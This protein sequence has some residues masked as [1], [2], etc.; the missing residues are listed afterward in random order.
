MRLRIA[1]MAVL[2]LTVGC[3]TD[4][5]KSEPAGGGG[6]DD[7]GPQGCAPGELVLG[8]GACLPAGIA[9][10]ECGQGFEPE[11]DGCA[12]ILPDAACPTGQ[13]VI[14][15]ETACHE[16]APCGDAPWGEIPIEAATVFVDQSFVGVSDGSEAA[17][18]TTVVEGVAAAP[19]GGMVAIAAG[20]YD[21]N[22][23]VTKPLRIWGR[24]PDLVELHGTAL[25]QPAFTVASGAMSAEVHSLSI[26]AV[27]FGLAVTGADVAV[28]RVWF[29][30]VGQISAVSQNDLGDATLIVTNSLFSEHGNVAFGA[31]GATAILEDSMVRDGFGAGVGAHIVTHDVN[32]APANGTVR[33]SYFSNN[34]STAINIL[35]STALIEDTVIDDTQPTASGLGGAGLQASTHPTHPNRSD[36]TVERSVFRRN[37][38]AGIL[39]HDTDLLIGH[40]VVRDTESQPVD[41]EGGDGVRVWTDTGAAVDSTMS[42]RSSL[43]DNNSSLGIFTYGAQANIEATIVRD[44]RSRAKDGL[45]GRGIAIQ[46]DPLTLES[47]V[48]TVNGCLVEGNRSSNIS[49]IG[50]EATILYTHVRDG[51][52]REED[53]NFGRGINV[54]LYAMPADP[55]Y[56]RRSNATISNVLVEDN[57]DAGIAIVGADVVMNNVAVFDTLAR[58][59][60]DGFGDGIVIDL[61]AA[62]VT[63][64]A[65]SLVADNINIQRNARA[66]LGNFAASVTVGNSVISCNTIDMAGEN[67]QGPFEFEDSGANVCGC[68]TE[69]IC[70]VLSSNLDP[71]AAIEPP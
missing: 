61:Y 17:P 52:P 69:K 44:T 66:G 32:G 9:P 67:A 14:P 56:A 49:V 37:H 45:T 54:Q 30:N 7:P 43:V 8:D 12:P 25:S 16:V 33:R 50:S 20:T 59:S 58:E 2:L 34:K 5:T 71:P 29:H 10:L 3:T 24:C 13:M 28:D 26:S 15:G 19:A 38:T 40:T 48:V 65:A 35:G 23:W 70:K 18:F 31:S 60:D 68:E 6:I 46:V 36:V 64:H 53:A 21:E 22:V 55:L 51:I 63:N 27:G 57:Y 42:I 41:G 4:K 47:S 11:S 39:V 1:S 62:M